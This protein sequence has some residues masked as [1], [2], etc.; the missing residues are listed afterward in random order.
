M[1][2]DVTSDC[3][4]DDNV[5]STHHYLNHS[6]VEVVADVLHAG[7][8]VDCG[9]GPVPFVPAHAQAAL[10]NGT[11]TEADIDE[12]MRVLLNV[13]F[14]LGHFDPV[15]PLQSLSDRR[16]ICSDE[17]IALSFDG[18]AQSA[19][20]LK[21]NGSALPLTP[22]RSVAVIGPN[23]N[24]SK[25]DAGYY[26][27]HFVCGMTFPTLVDAVARH[28]GRVV[29]MLAIRPVDSP[30][31]SN[32][33]AAVEMAKG[34]DDVVLAVG[35]DT[36]MAAEG[37][38]ASNISLSAAQLL[39]IQ[40]VAAAAKHPVTVVVMTAVPLDLTPLLADDKVGAILHVGQPSLTI[41]GV[42]PVLFGMRSPAGRL[43]QT[44]YPASYADEISIFDFVSWPWRW[45]AADTLCC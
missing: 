6:A 38:D 5:F 16:E 26:G 4:A 14:K 32:V 33:S 9:N 23:A 8:D 45:P 42:A 29:T 44:V 10:G 18:V 39:L 27:P 34:V 37:H 3:D 2:T 13:R 24:L 31:T 15:G 11:I 30:D 41:M 17:A 25:L 43:V 7:T 19:T 1:R 36:S 21:N 12:R 22:G 35:T 28:A 20:L 40:Q